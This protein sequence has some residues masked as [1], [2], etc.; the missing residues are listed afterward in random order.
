MRCQV[1]VVVVGRWVGVECGGMCVVVK[2]MMMKKT[3]RERKKKGFG[4]VKI[5]MVSLVHQASLATHAA[6]TV[7]VHPHPHYC[8]WSLC[9]SDSFSELMV[10]GLAGWW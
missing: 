8:F 2:K 9:L 5:P 1:V 3:M 6:A 7:V 10:I 4:G